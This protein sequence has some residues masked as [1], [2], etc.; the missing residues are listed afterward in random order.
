M[1]LTYEDFTQDRIVQLRLQKGV[2]AR[3]MSLSIGQNESYINQIENRKTLP[4]LPVLF[5]ICDY[6]HITP[7][8]FFDVGNPYPAQLADLMVDL[9]KLDYK[10]LELV[11]A[12]VRKLAG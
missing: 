8:Q 1:D 11:A 4:S 3:D 2:S 12:L 6:F 7:Q 9:K 10:T 5:Y